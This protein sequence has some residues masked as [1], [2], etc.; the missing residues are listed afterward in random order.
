MIRLEKLKTLPRK[1]RLRK[2]ITLVQDMEY[3]LGD[4]NGPASVPVERIIEPAYLRGLIQILQE[5]TKLPGWLETKLRETDSLLTENLTDPEA[6]TGLRRRCND[7][8]SG[9]Q[10]YFHI[11]PADWDFTDSSGRLLPAG[12]REIRGFT[13]FLEDLRSPFNVGSIFR[14][15]ES[16]GVERILLTPPVPTPEHKRVRRTAMGCTDIIPWEQREIEYCRKLENVFVLETG[17][18]SIE[19]FP[20]PERGT[21]IIGSEELGIS[22]EAAAFGASGLGRISISTGGV[23]GSLNVSVAF[24]ILMHAW[25]G[26]V[27][28]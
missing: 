28:S 10:Q 21:V 27:N 13:V 6:R 11:E 14:T 22:P 5:E 23:K 24:G 19:E 12:S 16:F 25:Y 20:F 4:E 7:I 1:T 3:R 8:R 15:A 18:T 9:L 17:G 26:S 2:I